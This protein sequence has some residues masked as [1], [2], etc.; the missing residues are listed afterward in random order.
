MVNHVESCSRMFTHV[1]LLFHGTSQLIDLFPPITVRLLQDR[2]RR[3]GVRAHHQHHHR[4]RGHVV[5]AHHHEPSVEG[6]GHVELVRD[7]VASPAR[8][9]QRLVAALGGTATRARYNNPNTF[10]PVSIAD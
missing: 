10:C 7:V 9:D 3:F 6:G 1:P 2:R 5:F 4:F 8:V